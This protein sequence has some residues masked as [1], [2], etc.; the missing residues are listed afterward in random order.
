M[1][2]SHLLDTIQKHFYHY[3]WSIPVRAFYCFNISRA[4]ATQCLQNIWWFL[5]FPVQCH[6]SLFSDMVNSTRRL[7]PPPSIIFPSN[8][9]THA[10][11]LVSSQL[12]MLT[13][14]RLQIASPYTIFDGRACAPIKS[15]DSNC[16][17]DEIFF[18]F[19]IILHFHQPDRVQRHFG[20]YR[21][22]ITASTFL[23]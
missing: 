22:S 11:T 1:Q 15:G 12:I 5:G 16:L 20:H 10:S 13:A 6:S 4:K 7:D 2:H 9:P 14:P 19:L 3:P 8:P 17:I 18:I 23:G 21:G